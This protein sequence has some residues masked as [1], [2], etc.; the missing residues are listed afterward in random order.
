M[1]KLKAHEEQITQNTED[2]QELKQRLEEKEINEEKLTRRI[3]ALEKAVGL[4]NN[5]Y[6]EDFSIPLN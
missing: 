3:M 2:I 6:I 5:I 1:Y 4:Q